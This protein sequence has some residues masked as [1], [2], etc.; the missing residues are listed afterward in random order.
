MAFGDAEFMQ[1]VNQNYKF[2]C[3]IAFNLIKESDGRAL[4]ISTLVKTKTKFDNLK[5]NQ[6]RSATWTSLA[7]AVV[8]VKEF[9]SAEE[10]VEEL[11]VLKDAWGYAMV[12]EAPPAKKIPRLEFHSNKLQ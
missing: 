2:P 8:S 9:A 11:K 3:T 5:Y 4:L 6:V 7:S 12:Q 1:K 10:Y